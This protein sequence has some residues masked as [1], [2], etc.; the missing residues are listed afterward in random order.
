MIKEDVA[1]NNV[2]VLWQRTAMPYEVVYKES[3]A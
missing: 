3:L 2:L 1:I